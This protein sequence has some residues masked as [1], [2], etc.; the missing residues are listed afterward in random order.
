MFEYEVIQ[1][2]GSGDLKKELNSLAEE[3]WRLVQ[4]AERHPKVSF[5]FERMKMSSNSPIKP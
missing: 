5:I 4:V 2:E 1:F 3:G